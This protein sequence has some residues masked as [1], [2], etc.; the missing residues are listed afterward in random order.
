M[1][2]VLCLGNCVVDLIARPVDRLPG[3]G[4]L[5]ML[6]TL[7][8]HLGGNGPNCAA[9][10]AR[11]GIPV[12]LTGRVGRDAFGE[13][14]LRA[15]EESGVDT[16]AVARDE[17][18]PTGVTF[19]AVSATGERSFLHSLGANATFARRDVDLSRI[20]GIRLLHA[21]SH[22]VLPAMDGA[23]LAGVLREAQARGITTTMDVCWD[24]SGG[25]L[26]T[27][28][29]CLPAV[30]YF[31]P[32][33]AEAA[34]LTGRETVAEMAAALRAAGARAVV[35]KC[36]GR[37]A[38]ASVAGSQWWEPA[39]AVEVIDSTGAGDCFVAGFVAGLL[40]GW[41]AD[42]AVRLGNA[43]GALA[44]TALGATQAIRPLAEIE[45]WMA[46]HPPENQRT[47]TGP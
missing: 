1:P 46:S 23:A 22:F 10:L 9:A 24:E 28:G 36:G 26:K 3:P 32:S 5:L 20:R 13:F 14:L 38:F 15:L 40:R 4:Q 39:F 27:L 11:L 45:S 25:W 44:T 43:C 34:A 42:R 31:L 6:E 41:Q 30:D 2:D 12:A 47:E 17:S 33:E 37:G 35:I 29:C 16:S 18:L 7:Q 8:A 21:G 19:V